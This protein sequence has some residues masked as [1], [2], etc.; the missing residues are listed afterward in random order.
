VGKKLIL[1]ELKAFFGFSPNKIDWES[2]NVTALCVALPF[3]IAFFV[4]DVTKG[5]IASLGGMVVMYFDPQSPITQRMIRVI[6]AAFG[7]TLSYAVGLICGFNQWLSALVFGILTMNIYCLVSFFKTRTPHSFFFIMM[8]A[9]AGGQSTEPALIT[10]RVGLFFMGAMLSC[11]VVFIFSM[12]RYQG[13]KFENTAFSILVSG[14]KEKGKTLAKAAILGIFMILCMSIGYLMRVTNPYWIPI[15][16]LAVMQANSHQMIWRRAAQRITGTFIGIGVFALLIHSVHHPLIVCLWIF[17]LQLLVEIFIRKNYAL[18][19]IFITP[20]TILLAE[21]G[22]QHFSFSHQFIDARLFD[23][24]IGSLMG[25]IGGWL[26]HNRHIQ[27]LLMKFQCR[28]F[29]LSNH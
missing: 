15:S 14:Q 18:A 11:I 7:L 17:I 24:S 2:N 6:M 21:T 29:S 23:I 19:V 8:A 1:A 5:L 10:Q 13:S 22:N 16:C 9:I 28:S 12:L 26:I 27:S 4:G 25:A 3:L 20:L